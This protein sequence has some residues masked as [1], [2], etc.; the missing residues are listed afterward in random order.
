[1]VLAVEL[2]LENDL[3]NGLLEGVRR[4]FPPA[5]TLFSRSRAEPG[6]E[7]ARGTNRIARPEGGLSPPEIAIRVV[8]FLRRVEVEP[9]EPAPFAPG[10]PGG[11]PKAGQ[12]RRGPG[13]S[14]VRRQARDEP[15]GAPESPLQVHLLLRVELP[16][17]DL[18]EDD[19]GV[20]GVGQD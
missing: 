3:F 2:E 15:G 14:H 19:V 6:N 13:G 4:A 16:G 17:D 11:G 8:P 1:M 9:L 12:E 7:G 10:R 5:I 18:A 20:L